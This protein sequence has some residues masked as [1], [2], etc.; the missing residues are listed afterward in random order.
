M[1]IIDYSSGHE[2]ELS[3]VHVALTKEEMK[4]LRDS[5]GLLL[6]DPDPF[7]HEHINNRAFDREV[8]ISFDV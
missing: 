6:D 2:R 1:K 8:I 4:E 5:L 3:Q 7:R